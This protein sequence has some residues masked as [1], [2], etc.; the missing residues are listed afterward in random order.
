MY[1][2]HIDILIIDNN[3]SANEEDQYKKIIR[4][5]FFCACIF[6]A[7]ISAVELWYWNV[8]VGWT[9]GFFGFQTLITVSILYCL[10]YIFFAKMYHALSIGKYRMTDLVFSQALSFGF[11]D[12]IMFVSSFSGSIISE[13]YI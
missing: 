12:A 1:L 5:Q 10:L 4:V 11:T 9:D 2:Y 6:L 8:G 13:G 3:G 7:G